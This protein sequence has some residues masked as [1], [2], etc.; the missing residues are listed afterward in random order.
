MK[1]WWILS[2]MAGLLAF[3][4]T[5]SFLETLKIEKADAE[6]AI[7]RSFSYGSYGGP[8]S[9]AWH[10]FAV[11]AR[12]T[13]VKEIGSFARTYSRSDDFKKRYA[14]YRE[15]Q[16]PS[17]PAPFVGVEGLKKQQREE[18]T[19]SIR[20]AKEAMKSVSGEA[21]KG[22]EE[23]VKAMEDVLK[24]LNNPDNPM[25]SAEV[26]NM[27]KQGWDQENQAYQQAL[28]AWKTEWPESPNQLIRNRLNYFLEL[29]ATVDFGAKLGKGPNGKMVFLNPAY[30]S[31]PSDWKLLY[32]CGKESVEAAR[33]V[34]KEWLVELK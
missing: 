17:A 25:Y 11:P 13:M 12:V 24:E 6:S 8:M 32:R 10:N 18:L 22:M 5:A 28:Q 20:E 26:N 27:L 7:W 2:V 29:S 21:R 4:F 1:K 34:A 16:K 14:E 19:K 33:G 15:Q 31:K 9:A 30:E 3:T 23:G